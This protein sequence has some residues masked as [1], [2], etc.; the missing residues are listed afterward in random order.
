MQQPGFQAMSG[1][2]R[3]RSVT[4]RKLAP[5]TFRR[6]IKF[7]APYRRELTIFLALILFDALIMVV[8]P[9]I[10][11]RIIDQGVGKG[12]TGLVT[13]L[14]MLVAGLAVVDAAINL[15]QRWY[16]ARIGEGLIYA[17]RAKVF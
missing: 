9:L 10:L 11:R 12:D 4:Q 2:R 6:I 5:G 8:N 16:S 14:A 13:R 17:M 15:V 1:F 3:D 7:A